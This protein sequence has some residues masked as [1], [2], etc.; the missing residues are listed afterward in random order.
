MRRFGLLASSTI[1]FCALSG[2]LFAAPKTAPARR[3][4]PTTAT[5]FTLEGLLHSLR[6]LWAANGSTIDPLGK[7]GQPGAA[8]TPPPQTTSADSGSSI[9]PFGIH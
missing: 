9:D 5:Q 6:S 4:T 1:L 2:P 8:P 7:P 3:A